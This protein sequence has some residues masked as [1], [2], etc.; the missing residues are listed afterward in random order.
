MKT[1]NT[2]EDSK[3]FIEE[4]TIVSQS[5]GR[6]VPCAKSAAAAVSCTGRKT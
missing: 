5:S 6:D 4:L 3:Y 1:T 2:K